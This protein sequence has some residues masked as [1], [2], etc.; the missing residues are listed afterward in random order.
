MKFRDNSVHQLSIWIINSRR[1]EC[2]SFEAFQLIV[3]YT[4]TVASFEKFEIREVI[5]FSVVKS[6]YKHSQAAV[7]GVYEVLLKFKS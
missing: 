3:G 1:I 5:R 2:F 7:C 4:I 6:H